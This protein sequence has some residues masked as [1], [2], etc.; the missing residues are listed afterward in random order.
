MLEVCVEEAAGVDA[1]VAGGGDRMELCAGLSLGGLTPPDSLIRI[2]AQAPIPTLMLA[3][4]RE[5]DFRYDSREAALV[6]ADITNAAQAGLEGVV[7]GASDVHGGLDLAL[8]AQWIDHARVEGGKRGRPVSLT[9]H[10]AFDLCP[11]PL[12]AL[13]DAITL[14]FDRILTSGGCPRAVDGCDMLGK[15]V[16]KADGRIIILAG[17][18][19]DTTNVGPILATGVTEIHASCRTP[20]G[21]AGDAERRFGFQTGPRLRTDAAK[22]AALKA[23]SASRQKP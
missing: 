4:P 14:G 13:E 7:I 5:G 10:R 8:L 12:A 9:L 22:V 2:A 20:L 16:R 17:G 11:D 15:L 18:G 6:A 23:L 3:R 21:T 19:V 1:A